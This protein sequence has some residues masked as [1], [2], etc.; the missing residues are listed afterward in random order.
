MSRQALF[1]KLVGQRHQIDRHLAGRPGS[2]EIY[3]IVAVKEADGT[4]GQVKLLA[5]AAQKIGDVVQLIQHI[6]GQTNLLALNAIIVSSNAYQKLQLYPMRRRYSC[7][8]T[9]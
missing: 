5:D 6:A 4:D 8:G 1:D 7:S 2:R 3:D 9:P